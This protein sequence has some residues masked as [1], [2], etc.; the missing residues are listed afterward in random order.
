MKTDAAYMVQVIENKDLSEEDLIAQL[1]L[2]CALLLKENEKA[3]MQSRFIAMASHEFRSPLTSIQLSASLLER[4]YDKMDHKKRTFHL[5]AIKNA[6][7]DIANILNDFLTTDGISNGDLKPSLIVF[8]LEVFCEDV[9]DEMRWMT[10]TNQ[11]IT[12]RHIGE[13]KLV[14]S[15]KS[16]LRHCLVNLLS[17]AIKYSDEYGLIGFETEV[18][19]RAF[20]VTIKDNGIGIPK[21]NQVHVFEA[22]FRADNTADIQGTGLGLS[23]VDHYVRLLKGRIAFS[24]KV[25]EGT[26]FTLTFPGKNGCMAEQMEH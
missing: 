17:N 13:K 14:W 12:Y 22:F 5:T 21:E 11:N 8:D 19:E 3:K 6:A 26:S 25:S 20:V 2:S 16:F 1:K 24:S 10:K 23:I 15:D 18:T 9:I 7:G 4:Y